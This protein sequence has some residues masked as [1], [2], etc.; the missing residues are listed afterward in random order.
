[1]L[2]AVV[3]VATVGLMCLLDVRQE[4][5][6][7]QGAA[8]FQT[9]GGSVQVASGS[10]V[11]G[12][13]CDALATAGGVKASG[14][15]RQGDPIVVLSMPASPV[16]VVEVTPGLLAMLPMIA[17]PYQADP[18]VT[19]G[20]WLSAD[21]AST[22]GAQPGTILQTDNG[23]ARVAGVYTWPSDGR[24]RDLGYVMI[25]PVTAD[26]DFGQC[27]ALSWPPD[28][29]GLVLTSL[30]PGGGGQASLNQLNMSLGAN[31]DTAGLLANRLTRPAPMVGGLIGLALGYVAVR[32]RRLEIASGLHARVPKTYLAWQHLIETLVWAGSASMIIAAA[33]IWAA[34]LGN[35]DPYWPIWA[36]AART[37]TT[38]LTATLIGA[39]TA[40][41]LIR[42]KHLFQYTK[43]R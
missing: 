7:L 1:V 5:A 42:E 32:T 24:A 11:S 21:L 28:Q 34:K 6:V 17:Q 19:G 8:T 27:W 30:N 39:T 4:V 36:T 14:A 33:L 20:V 3:F 23:P 26:T 25:T 37:I 9:A 31:Y 13:R 41:T 38:A 40:L 10:T 35:P 2:L 22:L 29:N 43:D 18:S 16:P 15:I 12:R